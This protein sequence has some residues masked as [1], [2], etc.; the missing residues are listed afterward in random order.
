M[1]KKGSSPAKIILVVRNRHGKTTAFVTD[2]FETLSLDN[3]ISY[4]QSGLLQGLHIVET[5]SRIYVRSDR[6][7]SKADNLGNLTVPAGSLSEQLSELTLKEKV[8]QTY[9]K[10]YGKFLELRNNKNE[11]IYLDKI[12]R[13][14]KEDVTRRLKPLVPKIRKSA[15]SKMIDQQLLGAILIDELARR[16]PDDLFDVLG[17]AG[18]NTSVGLAQVKMITARLVIEKGYSDISSSISTQDLYGLLTDDEEAVKFAAAYMRFIID[19]RTRRGLGTTPSDIA[20]A[21]SRGHN[22]KK[23]WPRGKTIVKDVIPMAKELLKL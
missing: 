7:Q 6:N 8:V 20:A 17:Y 1:S 10:A 12:A 4:I 15:K 3:V 9:L 5:K 18:A 11:L 2:A 21:Y 16:G 14:T 19:N 13:V 22:T 23:I